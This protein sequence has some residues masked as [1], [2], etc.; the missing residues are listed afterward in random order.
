MDRILIVLL[1]IFRQISKCK[2]GDLVPCG[3][4]T[5][6][7]IKREEMMTNS[8]KR[9]LLHYQSHIQFHKKLFGKNLAVV[10]LRFADVKPIG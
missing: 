1:N 3:R 7:Q 2:R 4:H 10:F 9:K 5:C 6:L 8:E